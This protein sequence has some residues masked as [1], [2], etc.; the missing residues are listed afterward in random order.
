[1]I[2]YS[3][4]VT[5]HLQIVYLKKGVKSMGLYEIKHA[6][7]HVEVA[8]LFGKMPQRYAKIK[9]LES[10]D[11]PECRYRA[12]KLAI[13][14]RAEPFFCVGDLEILLGTP[15]E[16]GQAEKLR[17]KII[18][19]LFDAYDVAG[20][21]DLKRVTSGPVFKSMIEAGKV[22]T[23]AG[24]KWQK[25]NTNIPTFMSHFKSAIKATLADALT[26]IDSRFFI[27]NREKNYTL[28][29]YFGYINCGIDLDTFRAVSKRVHINEALPKIERK[30]K[31][32]K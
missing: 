5:P 3:C 16:W 19:A 8:E 31:N 20:N 2:L 10:Q 11:C 23:K 27:D 17:F 4:G 12:D 21:D 1:M 18:N 29:A 25:P 26:T 6:C 24:V 28:A 14:K 13:A 15:S 32:A 7:G 30:D 22:L 9:W